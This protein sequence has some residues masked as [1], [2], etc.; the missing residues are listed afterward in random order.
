VLIQAA[1]NGY[2][3]RSVSH[4]SPA[5]DF[6]HST[7][8]KAP[9]TGINLAKEMLAKAGYTVEGGKLRYPAGKKEALQPP[10]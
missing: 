5:I 9:P 1:W 2:A 3:V 8:V 7:E 10:G 4:V 6:W